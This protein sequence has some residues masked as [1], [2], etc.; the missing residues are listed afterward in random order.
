MHHVS[1]TDG[2][3]VTEIWGRDQPKHMEL[4][5]GGK[6]KNVDLLGDEN[7]NIV[8]YTQK[9]EEIV[10]IVK[11]SNVFHEPFGL[12]VFCAAICDVDSK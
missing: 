2:R 11:A 5:V 10:K 9:V 7:L 6:T 1:V 4:G 8:M 12:N 3:S